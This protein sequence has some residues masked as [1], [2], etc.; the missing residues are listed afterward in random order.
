[1]QHAVRANP[2]PNPDPNPDSNP[3]PDPNPNPNPNPSP[4]PNPNPNPNPNKALFEELG[5][6]QVTSI[7]LDEDED[8]PAIQAALLEVTGQRTVPNIFV[9]GRHIGG[10]DDAQAKAAAGELQPMLSA[11]MK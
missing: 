11:A 9:G 8:G 2:N 7:A 4:I 10:N 5:A 6:Q 1:M 3:N